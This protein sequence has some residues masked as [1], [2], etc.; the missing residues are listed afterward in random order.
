VAQDDVLAGP[1]ANGTSPSD[2][3]PGAVST[4]M[5]PKTYVGAAAMIAVVCVPCCALVWATPRAGETF[6]WILVDLLLV[7]PLILIPLLWPFIRDGQLRMALPLLPI[8]MVAVVPRALGLATGG[9]AGGWALGVAG[10]AAGVV[11]GTVSAWSFMRWVAPVVMRRCSP[12]QRPTS[13]SVGAWQASEAVAP[14]D[15]PQE[16]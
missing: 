9:W 3:P 5:W 10:A 1:S 12:S 2:D 16:R 7:T 6:A 15:R 8:L 11:S 13:G 4:E 14:A